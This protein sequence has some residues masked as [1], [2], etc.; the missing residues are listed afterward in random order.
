MKSVWF[1]SDFNFDRTYT[2]TIF[3]FEP[4]ELFFPLTTVNDVEQ[5]VILSI[6]QVVFFQAFVSQIGMKRFYNEC[7]TVGD[8]FFV[9]YDLSF[10]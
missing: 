2:D 9:D 7:V 8:I 4:S 3:T 5:K 1:K 10:T 6:G